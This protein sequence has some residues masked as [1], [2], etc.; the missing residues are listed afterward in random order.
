MLSIHLPCNYKFQRTFIV[1]VTLS[2]LV[3]FSQQI[4]PGLIHFEKISIAWQ[5]RTEGEFNLYITYICMQTGVGALTLKKLT[6]YK[7][8][9]DII[10][11]EWSMTL[12]SETYSI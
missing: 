12:V 8:W 10:S 4:I 9:L 2:L 6:V 7:K 3:V 11:L 1:V 5:Q